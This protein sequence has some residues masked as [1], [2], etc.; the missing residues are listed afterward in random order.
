SLYKRIKVHTRY[1]LRSLFNQLD[2]KGSLVREIYLNK[3]KNNTIGI[4]RKELDQLAHLCP[5]LEILDFDQKIWKYIQQDSAKMMTERFQ[6]IKQLPTF[7][8]NIPTLSQNLTSLNLKG[9][10]VSDLF[11]NGEIVSQVLNSTPKLKYLKL[12]SQQDVSHAIHISL[13]DMELIH[14]TLPHLQELEMIGS[15]KFNASHVTQQQ[16]ESVPTSLAIR[17]LSLSKVALAYQWIYYFAHKYPL[18][19]ELD[20]ELVHNDADKKKLTDVKREEIQNLFS[21]LCKSCPRLRKIE[22][23]SLSAKIYLTKQF[24][25]DVSGALKEIKLKS[26]PYNV[27]T[28]GNDGF[29]DL[30]I[31]RGCHLITSL[32]TEVIGSDADIT[33][34]MDSLSTLPQLNELELHCGHLY[35][36]C[37]L[38]LILK[39]CPKLVKLTIRAA[40]VNLSTSISTEATHP[41][42]ALYL[43]DTLISSSVFDYLG[44]SCHS[45]DTL[46]LYECEQENKNVLVIKMPRNNFKKVTM[47]GIRLKT[48]SLDSNNNARFLSIQTETQERWYYANNRK[49]CHSNIQRLNH[50]KSLVAQTY[51]NH[52]VWIN[53]NSNDDG[54]D[55]WTKDLVLGQIVFE[56]KSI[57]KWDLIYQANYNEF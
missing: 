14:K 20:F 37:E 6:H 27:V 28:R 17:R 36:N 4:T 21:I 46:G 34:I 23:D 57:K 49:S 9:K 2:K 52:G 51:Y 48:V 40:N 24:F 35:F 44:K 53:N 54:R 45:L 22:L 16:I 32:A 33:S 29:F 10:I 38:D 15:F 31:E 3:S 55:S 42:K 25:D 13:S 41:L 18:L 47:N 50:R 39:A 11:Y 7:T 12:D 1:Q 26:L 8:T 56:C 19:Q 43:S 5:Y 30:L